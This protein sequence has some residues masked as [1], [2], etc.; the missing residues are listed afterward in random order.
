M[1]VN[2]P[3]YERRYDADL[4]AFAFDEVYQALLK[5]VNGTG[6]THGATADDMRRVLKIAYEHRAALQ[7]AISNAE[8][9]L[10]HR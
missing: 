1:D 7:R 2:S 10:G 9:W 3:E 5:S 8:I 4:K 6:P